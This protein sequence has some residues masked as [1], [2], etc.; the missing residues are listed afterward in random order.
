MLQ[1]E[2]T[3]VQE[4][5]AHDP[6]IEA[7]N[8]QAFGPGRFTRAAYRIREGGP[9]DRSLSFVALQGGIVVG[10]VRMTHVVIGITPALLLGPLAVRPEWKNRGIGRALMRMAMEAARLAGHRL[11]VLVGDELYYAPFGFRKV[12]PGRIMMPA[13]VDPNRLLAC[14]FSPRALENVS[15]LVRHADRA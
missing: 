2:L 10:S 7:I 11:V 12:E 4:G 15:G 14:E 1:L 3:Y 5:P 8:S 13:P 9:H 6:E